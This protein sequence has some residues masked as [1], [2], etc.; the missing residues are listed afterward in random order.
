MN[1]NRIRH[2]CDKKNV[3]IPT[4]PESRQREFTGESANRTRSPTTARACQPHGT[5]THRTTDIRRHTRHR[6]G[7]LWMIHRTWAKLPGD[8]PGHADSQEK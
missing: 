1:K 5:D 2:R 3:E 7:I 6:S 4:R 8:H